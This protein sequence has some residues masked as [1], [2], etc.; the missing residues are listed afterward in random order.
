VLQE[1]TFERVGGGRTLTADIRLV[2][3]TNRDLEAMVDAGQFREDLYHR[4]AVFPVELPPLRERREDIVP[5]AE[6]LLAR[7]AASL[8]RPALALTDGAKRALVAAPWRGNVRELANTLERAA[9]LAEGG[10]L[11]EDLVTPARKP[12]AASAARPPAGERRTLEDLERDAIERALN[13]FEGNRRKAAERLGIGLRTL[14]EK[15]KR[16]GMGG[17]GP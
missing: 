8:G 3:A 9:I 14:Y 13:E 15:L 17:P 6:T 7:I 12:R 10:T 2:A 4:L 11:D 5:I 16:Y 1:R